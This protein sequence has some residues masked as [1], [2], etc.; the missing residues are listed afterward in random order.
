MILCCEKFD[1]CA[2]T[3][4]DKF[5][6]IQDSGIASGYQNRGWPL[7]GGLSYYLLSAESSKLSS[8]LLKGAFCIWHLTDAS[9]GKFKLIEK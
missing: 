5:V 7:S 1:V 2:I 9:L 6:G 3:N 8:L 4:R